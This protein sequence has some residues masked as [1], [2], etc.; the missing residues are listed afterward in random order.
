M[1]AVPVLIYGNSLFIAGVA[2]RLGALPGVRL[3]RISSA[4]VVGERC[5][6]ILVCDLAAVGAEL[7]LGWL[8][9]CARLTLIGLD[10]RI[11]SVV[12]LSTE[13]RQ[14]AHVEDLAGLLRQLA[15]ST[16]GGCA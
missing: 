2:A 15:S 12:V 16:Q 4:N 1:D 7:V 13:T 3:E 8:T 5:P 14:L 6:A 9:S 11:D 10:P